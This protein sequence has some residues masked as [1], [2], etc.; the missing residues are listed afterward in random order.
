M[1]SP[2]VIFW[3]GVVADIYGLKVF[4]ALLGKKNETRRKTESKE[5]SKEGKKKERMIFLKDGV[6]Q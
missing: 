5:G 1:S 4:A 2:S 6:P 3:A